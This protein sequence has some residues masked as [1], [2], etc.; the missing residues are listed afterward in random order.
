MGWQITWNDR[1]YT[2]DDMTAA[3]V[4]LIMQAQGVDDWSFVDPLGGPV[5]LM[6]VLAA[7]VSIG[8]QR[9]LPDVMAEIGNTPAVNFIGA[10]AEA[11]AP[12]PQPT[13]RRQ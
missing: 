3:H 9:E 10:I 6:G 2:E 7:F 1:T 11:P 12:E 4:A 8:E 5:K 13:R